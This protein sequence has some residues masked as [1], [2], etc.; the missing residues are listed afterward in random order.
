MQPRPKPPPGTVH[1]V[2]RVPRNVLKRGGKVIVNRASGPIE[3]QIP[4]G[5]KVGSFI[6]V[7]AQGERIPGDRAGPLI[8]WLT[9]SPSQWWIPAV[10]LPLLA[11]TGFIVI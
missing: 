9:V 11:C 4:S 10:A 1:E 6:E 2:I 3:L 8:V 7:Q 5:S